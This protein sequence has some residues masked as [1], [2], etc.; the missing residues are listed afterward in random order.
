MLAH[1]DNSMDVEGDLL[2]IGTPSLVTEA[3]KVFAVVLGCE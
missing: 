3:V 1:V 2:G